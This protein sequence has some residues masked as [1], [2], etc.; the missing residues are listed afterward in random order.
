MAK[1]QKSLTRKE[2][3][4]ESEKEMSS[5]GQLGVWE[6]SKCSARIR[7]DHWVATERIQSGIAGGLAN[8]PLSL[9]PPSHSQSNEGEGEGQGAW[10]EISRLWPDCH[11]ETKSFRVSSPYSKAS[12]PSCRTYIPCGSL[13]A[14]RIAPQWDQMCPPEVHRAPTLEATVKTRPGKLCLGSD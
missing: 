13:P 4:S 5:Q 1:V 2:R 7:G 3:E 11:T 6:V 14:R 8:I 10:L 9:R 12:P